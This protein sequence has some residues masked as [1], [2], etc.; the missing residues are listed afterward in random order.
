LVPDLLEAVVPVGTSLRPIALLNSSQVPSDPYLAT[1]QIGRKRR[2]PFVVALRP[3]VF[4]HQILTFDITDF[5]QS[6]ES[7]PRN[8]ITGRVGHA[9]RAAM[10]LSRRRVV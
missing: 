7:P 9:P 6:G 5:L 3:A 8:P 2:Q 10:R 1:N 4:D